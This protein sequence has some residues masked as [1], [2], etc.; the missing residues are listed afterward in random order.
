MFLGPIKY[1][2]IYCFSKILQDNKYNIFIAEIESNNIFIFLK[3][4][5]KYI[6]SHLWSRSSISFASSTQTSCGSLHDSKCVCCNCDQP[7][8]WQF[9]SFWER[10]PRSVESQLF[11]HLLFHHPFVHQLYQFHQPSR[12]RFAEIRPDLTSVAAILWFSQ[13]ASP[14]SQGCKM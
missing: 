11:E 12:V 6:I 13:Q 5:F 2:T 10:R 3:N 14:S 9:H 1:F 8:S 7:N 4:I